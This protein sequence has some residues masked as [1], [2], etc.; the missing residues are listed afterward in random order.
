MRRVL[1]RLAVRLAVA[2]ESPADLAVGDMAGGRL[3]AAGC[4]RA[5]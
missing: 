4:R 3:P 2:L 5:S 1:R